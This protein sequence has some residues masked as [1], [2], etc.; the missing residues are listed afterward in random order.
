MI[1]KTLISSG[2]AIT[3]LLL[4]APA[5]AAPLQFELTGSRQ[6][7]FIL[8][9]MPT[10]DRANSSTLIGDQIFFDDFAGVFGG[11]PGTADISFGT[12]VIA[13]LNIQSPDLGFTQFAGPDLF[14]G[15]AGG[16]VFSTGTFNLTSLV[17]GASTLTISE[18]MPGEQVSEPA[19]H[20]LLLGGLGFTAVAIR[21]RK[22][23]AEKATNA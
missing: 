12:G 21:R 13:S 9:S 6:A 3:A 17:S 10:P 23:A 19:T 20:G 16:P 1:C 2:A 15:G 18:I 4:T 5:S 11:V 8:D 22:S 14:T 7:S